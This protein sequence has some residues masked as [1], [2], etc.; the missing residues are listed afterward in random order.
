MLTRR[1]QTSSVRSRDRGSSFERLEMLQRAPRRSRRVCRASSRALRRALARGRGVLHVKRSKRSPGRSGG[2]R[3]SSF[4]DTRTTSIPRQLRPRAPRSTA[5]RNLL[6]AATRPV[7][8]VHRYRDLLASQRGSVAESGEHRELQRL[9]V[10][11]RARLRRRARAARHRTNTPRA[12]AEWRR[13]HLLRT[14]SLHAER[15]RRVRRALPARARE[16]FARSRKR[17][18]APAVITPPTGSHFRHP[19]GSHFHGTQRS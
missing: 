4:S 3:R 15:A 1:R 5:A 11:R 16:A 9:L 14:R 19:T 6:R 18:P 2:A 7:A 12:T 17:R 13:S 10:A 8:G